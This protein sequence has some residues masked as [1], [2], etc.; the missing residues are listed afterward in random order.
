MVR[1]WVSLPTHERYHRCH[2]LDHRQGQYP[3]VH[4]RAGWCRATTREGISCRQGSERQC[5]AIA[6]AILAN[7]ALLVLDEA[8]ASLDRE[9]GAAVDEVDWSPGSHSHRSPS[10]IT[11]LAVLSTLLLRTCTRLLSSR[12]PT[13]SFILSSLSSSSS[14]SS[15]IAPFALFPD[16]LKRPHTALPGVVGRQRIISAGRP[17]AASWPDR[18]AHHPPRTRPRKC[19]SG[20]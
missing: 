20:A 19:R 11:L 14:S 1:L 4:L 10:F 17:T 5:A 12:C 7:P 13:H 16:L 6:R 8:T 15:C 9:S 18:V 3:W 2:H